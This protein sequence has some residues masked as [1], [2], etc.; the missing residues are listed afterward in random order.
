MSKK[1]SKNKTRQNNQRK[2]KGRKMSSRRGNS[3]NKKNRTKLSYKK[4]RVRGGSSNH[5]DQSILEKWKQIFRKK[6][7]STEYIKIIKQFTR[8]II[9]EFFCD[10]EDLQNW[11]EKIE[12][13]VDEL[14]NGIINGTFTQEEEKNNI[15]LFLH[16]FLDGS[17]IRRA[18]L[19]HKEDNMC[20]PE[21]SISYSYIRIANKILKILEKKKKI[22]QISEL[23]REW[24]NIIMSKVEAARKASKPNTNVMGAAQ[25]ALETLRN[26]GTVN[27]MH[28][29]S[30]GGANETGNVIEGLLGE[31]LWEKSEK[32]CRILT[33][34]NDKLTNNKEHY[35]KLIKDYFTEENLATFLRDIS[36]EKLFPIETINILQENLNRDELNKTILELDD[37]ERYLTF[38]SDLERKISIVKDLRALGPTVRRANAM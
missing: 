7:E 22:P 38:L 5:T 1:Q 20:G 2:S 32:I 27:F 31:M 25:G 10:K 3:K 36:N 34:T 16:W 17:A 24:Y 18:L 12:D 8:E 19:Y 37:K 4:K 11:E 33:I 9:E 26:R 30:S 13:I 35:K 28:G 21:N 15:S 23:E 6:L 14:I 29:P